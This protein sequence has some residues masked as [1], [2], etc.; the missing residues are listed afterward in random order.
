VH[1]A[2]VIALIQRPARDYRMEGPLKLRFTRGLSA[3]PARFE[4]AARLLDVLGN[5][6]GAE[7]ATIGA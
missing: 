7:A 5:V 6:A 3:I 4:F 1:A 2:A